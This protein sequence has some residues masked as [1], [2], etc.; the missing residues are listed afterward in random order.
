MTILTVT[1]KRPPTYNR[2]I[3]EKYLSS[4]GNGSGPIAPTAINMMNI[5]LKTN[6]HYKNC[7]ALNLTEIKYAQIQ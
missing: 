2:K 4:R 1:L 5:N 3:E 6:H 7:N